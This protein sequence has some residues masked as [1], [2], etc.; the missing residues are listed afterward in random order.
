MRAAS[1]EQEPGQQSEPVRVCADCH[2]SKTVRGVWY[3]VPG[4]IG[5]SPFV[6]EACFSAHGAMRALS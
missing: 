4:R 6:C 1:T 5:V 2:R 3:L